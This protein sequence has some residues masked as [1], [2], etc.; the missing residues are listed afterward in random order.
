[1]IDPQAWTVPMRR[2]APARRH[3]VGME[4]EQF[5]RMPLWITKLE[6]GDASRTRGQSLRSRSRDGCPALARA[7]PRIGSLH[8]GNHDGDV[9]ESQVVAADI[10]RVWR[11]RLGECE[12]LDCLLAKSE[13]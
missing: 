4:C 10:G 6:R 11:T 12:E 13:W 1:M 9:L 2:L 5:E 7:Q 3:V 8:V